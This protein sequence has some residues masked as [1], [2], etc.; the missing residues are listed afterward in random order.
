MKIA[1]D[2]VVNIVYTLSVKGGETPEELTREH[3]VEYLHGHCQTLPLLEQ[4]LAGHSQ[5]DVIE[6]T[7]PSDQAFGSYN[8]DLVNRLDVN[9]L[10]YPEKLRQG[11]VYEEVGH[12]GRIVRFKVKELDGGSVVADFNHPAAG[13]DLSLRAS[14]LA[15]RAASPVDIMKALHLRKG[16]G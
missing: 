11:E 2:T 4:A 5:G 6:I 8:E 13:M 16:G 3:R 7:I 10:K 12:D 9:N 1:N 14:I 15:V